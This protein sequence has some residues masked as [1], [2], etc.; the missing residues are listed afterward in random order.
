MKSVGVMLR[1]FL[2]KRPYRLRCRFKIE[3]IPSRERLDR[4]KVRVAERF[5]RDMQKQGWV[6]DNRFGFRMRGPF[7]PIE[8][9]TIHI[10]RM[11]SA[12]QMLPYVAQGARFLDKGGTQAG[13]M[14]V[15]PESNYWEYE[16]AGVFVRDTVLVEQPDPHEEEKV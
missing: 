16:L 3:P 10:A 14:P 7:P 1:P 13:L 15:L 6:Y 9:T 11:P 2:P 5:V 12:K 8:P 4:E